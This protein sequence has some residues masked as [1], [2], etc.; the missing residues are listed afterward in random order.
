MAHD[1]EFFLNLALR[2]KDAWNAWR[3]DPANEDVRVIFAGI[4]FSEAPRDQINFSGFEFPDNANFSW[5][6]WRD[7]QGAF[8]QAF[9]PGFACFIN[10][11]FGHGTDFTG[12]V[13]GDSATFADAAF[14]HF[15]IFTYAAF[16]IAAKFARATFGGGANFTDAVFGEHANFTGAVFSGGTDFTAVAFGSMANFRGAIF[17]GRVGFTGIFK[18]QLTRAC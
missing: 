18:E 14:G 3:R 15:T 6:K 13:F 8:I 17:K 10:A 9:T 1:Q 11:A 7:C 5:C 2:G 16:G 4:D 12:T